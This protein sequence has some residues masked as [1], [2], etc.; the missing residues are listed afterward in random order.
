DYT[1]SNGKWTAEDLSFGDCEIGACRPQQ[2]SWAMNLEQQSLWKKVP[3]DLL[4]NIRFGDF[5]ITGK[6]HFVK[7]ADKK[8]KRFDSY[9]IRG[10]VQA[11]IVKINKESP[12][13]L[14]G[15][16]V[17][18]VALAPLKIIGQ[19]S[20]GKNNKITEDKEYLDNVTAG[21]LDDKTMRKLVAFFELFLFDLFP[22]N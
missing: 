12:Q 17:E 11:K 13:K 6:I 9:G 21:T 1:A 3:S 8:S 20:N 15:N 14:E 18:T 22:E 5:A 10:F 2:Y 16:A 19:D 4:L 7:I